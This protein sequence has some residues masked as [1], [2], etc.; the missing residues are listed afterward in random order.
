MLREREGYSYSMIII[1][2]SIMIMI[3]SCL[4]TYNSMLKHNKNAGRPDAVPRDEA[5][6]PRLSR[7]AAGG[8]GKL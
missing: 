6:P 7:A 3:V 4:V 1:M 5:R 8:S 2:I